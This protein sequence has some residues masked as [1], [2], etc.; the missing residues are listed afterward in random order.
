MKVARS[1]VDKFDMF[2]WIVGCTDMLL[3]NCT[4]KMTFEKAHQPTDLQIKSSTSL[5]GTTT[6]YLDLHFLLLPFLASSLDAKNHLKLP[7]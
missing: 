2:C 4:T 3:L 7:K 1:V 6:V 5:S